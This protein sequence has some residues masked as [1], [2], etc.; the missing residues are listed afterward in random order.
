M[1]I[2]NKEQ[3]IKRRK[4]IEQEL[5]EMLKDVGSI[6]TLDHIKDVIYYE[7][8]TDDM[9]KVNNGVRPH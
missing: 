2:E 7:K 4:E 5:I 9:T 8:E 6:F 1:E 3:I